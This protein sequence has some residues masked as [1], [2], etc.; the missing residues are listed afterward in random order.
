MRTSVFS[1][2][3]PLQEKIYVNRPKCTI[4]NIKTCWIYVIGMCI[5]F[6]LKLN[7]RKLL[8][9]MGLWVEGKFILVNMIKIDLGNKESSA[10]GGTI[11][12]AIGVCCSASSNLFQ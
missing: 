7:N 12:R 10:G 11:C 5:I 2:M 1:T 4:E 8:N 9:G 6:I 3:I